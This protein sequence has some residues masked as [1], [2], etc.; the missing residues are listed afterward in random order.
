MPQ[1][2]WDVSAARILVFSV[3]VI[4]LLVG[5]QMM[6]GRGCPAGDRR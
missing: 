6:M 2:G 3:M 4:L 1:C 5:A